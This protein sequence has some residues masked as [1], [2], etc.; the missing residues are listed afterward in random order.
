M[1]DQR[2]GAT[3]QEWFHF[4]DWLGLRPDLLPVVSNPN[5]KVSASSKLKALGKTPSKYNGAGEVV[6]IHK[7][8][9]KRATT[10]EI[11]LWAREGDYGIC[12]QTRL[13]RG[14]DIDCEDLEL[15]DAIGDLIQQSLGVVLPTRTRDKSNRLLL[16]LE[17]PGDISKRVCKLRG[18]A[19]I[20]EFLATGQQFVACGTHPSGARYRW[21]SDLPY[22]IPAVPIEAFDEAWTALTAEFADPEWLLSHGGTEGVQHQ[23]AGGKGGNPLA[24]Q[25]GVDPVV[26]W[27]DRQGWVREISRG[28][29]FVWCPWRA[30][31]SGDSGVTESEW[32][33]GGTGGFELGHYKCLH[34]H[35]SDRGRDAFLEEVGYAHAI[36]G[37]FDVVEDDDPVG[38]NDP[39]AD[40]DGDLDRYADAY[41]YAN[42]GLP[43]DQAQLLA[44][45]AL[46]G[47]TVNGVSGGVAE[48]RSSVPG[49][50]L[51]R[52]KKGFIATL[53]NVC[54]ALNTDGFWQ[55]LGYD[56]FNQSVMRSGWGW[57]GGFEG[58]TKLGDADYSR[59]RVALEQAGFEP[60]GRELVRD[61]VRLVAEG[62]QFDSAQMW[63]TGLEGTWTGQMRVE[64]FF[65]DYM[66]VADTPFARAC[67]RYFWTALAGRVMD[68]GCQADMA[69]LLIGGQGLKKTR[70]FAAVVPWPDLTVNV[71]LAHPD[72]KLAK[73]V[74]GRLLAVMSE[75]RGMRTKELEAIKDWM[76]LSHDV[77]RPLWQEFEVH[78][79]RRFVVVGT[80][81][82]GARGL[83]DD[84]TGN[85][86]WLP[87]NIDR[88]I[89]DAAIRR[90]RD[91]LW[92]EALEMWRAGGVD[93]ADA[94]R[95][96]ATEHEE[97]RVVDS[98]EGLLARWLAKARPGDYDLYPS[99]AW[100]EGG[101]RME[102]VVSE[103][104]GLD[105]RQC[106]NQIEWRVGK[107]LRGAGY[108][109]KPVRL[110]AAVEKRWLPLVTSVLP[111]G[112]GEKT[113]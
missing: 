84:E 9:E 14:V 20:V 11:D 30:E 17:I 82:P 69:V 83:F 15:G 48:W 93:W 67:G 8:T 39:I 107:I 42:L 101:F 25:G 5:A 88:M 51:K 31:H 32:L 108:L 86:R 92:A 104:F 68:P 89:D 99:Q 112:E 38:A 111:Q 113:P 36:E 24:L 26:D 49:V 79:P 28:R 43:D 50:G 18:D 78:N 87:I 100:K 74:R 71:D 95:L 27:L 76:T 46:A 98:W 23:L 66:G 64:R 70:G 75:M 96:S 54:R 77:Y 57:S 80:W 12:V 35:C 22:V 33:R 109:S 58:W 6:G 97:H 65:V 110:G 59:A 34:A 3:P 19:G 61:A 102:D 44:E 94:A 47:K 41:H 29:V 73:R 105:I 13:V 60:V 90:D 52:D 56:T 63:L 62:R 16:A 21:H 53:E 4:A 103:A 10:G 1:A 85:R 45:Q 2:W 7:W 40:R 37:H 91:L 55:R 72:E 106:N 81:N